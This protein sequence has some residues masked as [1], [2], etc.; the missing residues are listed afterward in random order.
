MSPFE[1]C[2]KFE[3]I[4]NGVYHGD[5]YQIQNCMVWKNGN[6]LKCVYRTIHWSIWKTDAGYLIVD[7]RREEG[8]LPTRLTKLT[9]LKEW[10]HS[11]WQMYN[12]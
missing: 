10:T 4:E 2:G 5:R 11:A 7:T 9:E 3:K 6:M 1:L 8:Y 12:V